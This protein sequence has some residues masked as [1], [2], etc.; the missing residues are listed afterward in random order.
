VT[1][2]GQ[3]T[4]TYGAGTV[5]NLVAAAAGGYRFVHWT[6]NVGTVANVSAASTAITMNGDYSITAGFEA[7]PAQQYHLAL[8]STTG[9]SVT[10]PGEGTFAYA[11]GTVVDLVAEADEGYRFVEWTGGTGTIGDV[12]T[13]QTTVTMNL[14][15]SIIANFGEL[16]PAPANWWLIAGIVAA[17]V[18]AGLQIFF[19]LRRRPV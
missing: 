18:A 15:C 13:G 5:V 8:S 10:T 3:G 16:R 6:G 17:V 9:G 14:D 19:L 4:F 7:I 2:P 11:G 1:S 12:D